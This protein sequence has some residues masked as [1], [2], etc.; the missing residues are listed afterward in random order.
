VATWH[1]MCPQA[2]RSRVGDLID[3][4]EFGLLMRQRDH[5]DLHS[6][7][8]NADWEDWLDDFE[9]KYGRTPN[10]S[11]LLGQCNAMKNSD[12]YKDLIRRGF[13]TWMSYGEWGGKSK[14]ILRLKAIL[15][16]RLA[17]LAAKRLGKGAAASIPIIS[18]F[19]SL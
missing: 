18:V 16:K 9:D 3:D 7:G 15:K 2:F 10:R 14:A 1:H 4:P 11:E 17:W 8:W 6:A 19:F 13:P 5:S 12:K